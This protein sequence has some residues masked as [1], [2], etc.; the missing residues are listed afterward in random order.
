MQPAAKSTHT[1][2]RP[3]KR[4]RKASQ[5]LNKP[6][7]RGR[8]TS[9]SKDLSNGLTIPKN[10]QSAQT[11]VTT[12]AKHRP[13]EVEL[14]SASIKHAVL[15]KIGQEPLL[16][17]V[18]DGDGEARLL[19]KGRVGVKGDMVLVVD[20][21]GGQAKYHID[22]NDLRACRYIYTSPSF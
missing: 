19:W 16:I 7:S 20:T 21:P 22:L 3:P 17:G 2:L 15:V 4:V 13:G 11:T 9:S 12:E 6:G 18:T 14:S 8:N 10:L 5:F 1:A